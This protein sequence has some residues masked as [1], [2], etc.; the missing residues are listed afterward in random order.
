[1]AAI[2]NHKTLWVIQGQQ[3]NYINNF[4]FRNGHVYPMIEFRFF[5]SVYKNRCEDV[6]RDVK[7]SDPR[8]RSGKTYQ[9]VEKDCSG[10][11]RKRWNMNQQ[12]IQ[13]KH[14]LSLKERQISGLF[15]EKD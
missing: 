4:E 1:M 3:Y 7:I 8:L 6:R 13:K 5:T 12:F 14:E 11:W 2:L 15:T 9:M 10:V